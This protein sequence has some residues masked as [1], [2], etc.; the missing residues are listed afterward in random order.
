MQNISND[1]LHGKKLTDILEELVAYYGAL[2]RL[3]K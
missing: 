1:P 2:M 3:G